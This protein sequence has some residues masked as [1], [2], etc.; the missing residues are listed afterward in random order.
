MVIPLPI[1]KSLSIK[2]LQSIEIWQEGDVF[3]AKPALSV[4]DAFGMFKTSGAALKK[5]IKEAFKKHTEKK[6]T[7]K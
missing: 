1:R 2:P 7:R 5:D 3:S 6:Y 4:N